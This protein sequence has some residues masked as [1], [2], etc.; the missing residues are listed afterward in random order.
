M[1]SNPGHMT[2]PFPMCSTQGRCE[3]LHIV[4]T[5]YDVHI[6]QADGVSVHICKQTQK[7]CNNCSLFSVDL[8]GFNN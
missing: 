6:Q 5:C 1:L 2:K 7:T 8:K 4:C 3:V